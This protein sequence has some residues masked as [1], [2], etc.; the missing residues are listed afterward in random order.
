MTPEPSQDG[1]V[2]EVK[3]NFENI[4]YLHFQFWDTFLSFTPVK[5][6]QQVRIFATKW[7]KISR[8]LRKKRALA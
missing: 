7:A 4:Q 3:V 5:V 2:T 8:S 6:H 1:C